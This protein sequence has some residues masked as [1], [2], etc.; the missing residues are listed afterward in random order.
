MTSNLTHFGILTSGKIKSRQG[1]IIWDNTG[2]L[3]PK[4]KIKNANR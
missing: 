4:G 3:T 1:E 2:R